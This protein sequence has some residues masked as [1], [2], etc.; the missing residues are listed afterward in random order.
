MAGR[1]AQGSDHNQGLS[2]LRGDL[3][4]SAEN[5]DPKV[6]PP[7]CRCAPS[8]PLVLLPR[9]TREQED[10]LHPNRSCPIGGNIIAGNM[11]SQLPKARSGAGDGIA[12]DNTH[13]IAKIDDS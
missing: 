10:H 13:L 1:P 11:D 6:P 9:K 3:R 4:V 2:H 7:L 12:G 5:L 8:R